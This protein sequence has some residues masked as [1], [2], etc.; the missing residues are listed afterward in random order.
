MQ[1]S[2]KIR[3]SVSEMSKAIPK[4]FSGEGS[5]FNSLVFSEVS[6][7]LSGWKIG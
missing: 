6:G 7:I 5:A 3:F 2:N 1:N 4:P